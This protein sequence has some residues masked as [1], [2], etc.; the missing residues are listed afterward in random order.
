MLSCLGVYSWLAWCKFSAAQES[1]CH[2]KIRSPP[3]REPMT[4]FFILIFF[5]KGRRYNQYSGITTC[6]WTLTTPGGRRTDG[7][8]RVLFFRGRLLVVGGLLFRGRLPDRRSV[9]SL[10]L[11]SSAGP[12][13]L[14]EF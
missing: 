8:E 1:I 13:V 9:C 4:S 2:M 12:E 14:Q 11:V 7:W 5:V 3:T 6:P 10:V